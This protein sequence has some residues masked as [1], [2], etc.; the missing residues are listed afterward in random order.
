M[1]FIRRK[2]CLMNTKII[3]Q[4]WSVLLHELK[5]KQTLRQLNSAK[6]YN[7]HRAGFGWLCFYV[8]SML[9]RMRLKLYFCNIDTHAHEHTR[10]HAFDWNVSS[11]S[12]V[13]FD[14][15]R[16]A[17]PMSPSFSLFTNAHNSHLFYMSPSRQRKKWFSTVIFSVKC[18][19]FG[20]ICYRNILGLAVRW[21]LKSQ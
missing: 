7:V 14:T 4:N 5:P 13:Y 16:Y 8:G 20:F 9:V 15:R 12:N 21:K 1:N 19:L 17:A 6:L 11:A 3:W 10:I 2:K 18:V